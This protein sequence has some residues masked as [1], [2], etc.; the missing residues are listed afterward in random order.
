MV[1][2]I[3][4]GHWLFRYYHSRNSVESMKVGFK[5]KLISRFVHWLWNAQNDEHFDYK[6]MNVSPEEPFYR[7]ILNLCMSAA[8]VMRPYYPRKLK[9]VR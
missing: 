1:F 3:V 5:Q 2:V 9:Q 8:F 6:L 4:D 7:L